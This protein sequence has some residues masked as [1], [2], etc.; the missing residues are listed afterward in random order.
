MKN[1]GKLIFAFILIYYGYG[2]FENVM[3]DGEPCMG[4]L[5]H[6]SRAVACPDGYAIFIPEEKQFLRCED[7]DQYVNIGNK[8]VLIGSK[9]IL[10]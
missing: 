1:L 6:D 4:W 9:D 8:S 3:L 7:W 5:C 10:K 2:V